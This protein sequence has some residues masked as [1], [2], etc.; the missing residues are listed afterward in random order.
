MLKMMNLAG[1]ASDCTSVAVIAGVG[2]YASSDHGGLIQQG[3]F[4]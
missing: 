1:V 2:V 4:V 3:P